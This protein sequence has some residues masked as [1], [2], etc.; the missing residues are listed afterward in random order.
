[1]HLGPKKTMCAT[2]A[3]NRC[4]SLITSQSYWIIPVCSEDSIGIADDI[5]ELF[6]DDE[7]A[8]P[9]VYRYVFSLEFP[10]E[11]NL[12]LMFVKKTLLSLDQLNEIAEN[13]GDPL[14]STTD[15]LVVED[16][17]DYVLAWIAEHFD[18]ET[19]PINN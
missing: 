3:I 17:P 11:P 12:V 8:T 14:T 1:M 9:N 16:V 5:Y 7:L 18:F 15:L 13:I 4:Q 6:S 2:E 10:D 19:P